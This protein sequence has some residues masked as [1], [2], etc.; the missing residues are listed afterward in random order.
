MA[1]KTV[2]QEKG[3]R[4]PPYLVFGAVYLLFPCVSPSLSSPSSTKKKSLPQLQDKE[5]IILSCI[6]LFSWGCHKGKKP[7]IKI[8]AGGSRGGS[9]IQSRG[10]S[11]PRP[12]RTPLPFGKTGGE[13]LGLGLDPLTSFRVG[14]LCQA[15]ADSSSLF[16]TIWSWC[17]QGN[18]IFLQPWIPLA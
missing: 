7:S 12:Q 1:I 2:I 13:D 14:G 15:F 3:Q 4:G 17:V 8:G 9:S 5:I 16:G 18:S 11:S 10:L 6:R